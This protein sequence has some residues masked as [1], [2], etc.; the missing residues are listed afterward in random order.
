MTTPQLHFLAWYADMNSMTPEQIDNITE[1]EYYNYYKSNLTEY[2]KLISKDSSVNYQDY[3]ILDA[4]NGIGGMQ[5]KKL[6]IFKNS[7]AYGVKPVIVNDGSTGIAR[8]N[9]E[10]GAEYVHKDRKF[11]KFDEEIKNDELTKWIAFDGDADRIVYFYGD[12]STNTINVVDGDKIAI[13]L[14]DYIK[15][16]IND[17]KKDDIKL[18]DIISFGVVQ[19]GYANSAASKYLINKGVTVAKSLTGVKNMH[20][21]AQKFDIGIYFEANGHGTIITKY[22]KI[23]DILNQ[24]KFDMNNEHVSKFLQFLKLTNEAVG[25]SMWVLMMM[26]AFLKDRDMSIQ[27]ADKV[28]SDYPSRMLKVSVKKRENFVTEADDETILLKPEGLQAEIEAVWSK[29]TPSRAFARPSG[30]EDVV[31]IYAEGPTQE[32]ADE[33]GQEILKIISTK[34]KD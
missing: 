31:R 27:M 6:D 9:D 11:P 7:E 32:K 34:Y 29:V 13:L 23:L 25:D 14:G 28:Y 1:E 3:F 22:K 4:S 16:L 12:I 24:N 19:T 10:C 15:T 2:Y 8:L 30:T 33:I 18:E 17:V 20:H 5:A 26:E 21:K